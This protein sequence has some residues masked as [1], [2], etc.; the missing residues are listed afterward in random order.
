[1]SNNTLIYRLPNAARADVHSVPIAIAWILGLA[2]A[3]FTVQP[4]SFDVAGIPIQAI[5]I[6]VLF[7]WFVSIRLS[8][9]EHGLTLFSGVQWS[10][11]SV[12]GFS[13]LIRSVSDGDLLRFMQFVTGV[14]LAIVG[15]L[16]FRGA[17][18]RKVI[19]VSLAVTAALSG[20]IAVIQHYEQLSW[21]FERTVYVEGSTRTPSGLETSPVP[22]AYSV[23]GIQVVL[24]SHLIF[25]WRNRIRLMS[26]PL[27]M[28]L[29][30]TLSILAGLVVSQSRSGL[31]G[32]VAAG[33]IL[34]IGGSIV[35]LRILPRPVLIG[36]AVLAVVYASSVKV[37]DEVG[38]T[39]DVRLSTT[40]QAYVPLIWE[41]PVGYAN[42]LESLEFW[43]RVAT[44]DRSASYLAVMNELGGVAPH[45][46]IL[47]T[48]VAYGA[49]AAVALVVLY[50]TV[51]FN[52]VKRLTRLREPHERALALWI[53]TLIATNVA[54]LVHSWFHNANLA[55]GEM[56]NWLW[57]GALSAIT[58]WKTP[59]RVPARATDTS[60]N[61]DERVRQIAR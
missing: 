38:I 26:I 55:T 6:W 51:L 35:G 31:L 20:M 44:V 54:V 15:A 57:I 41:A 27:M 7:V 47:T 13:I 22:F 17:H 36:L 29:V 5:I 40:W 1:M 30:C 21:T 23:V 48:G 32:I 28:S 60:F 56:R 11:V 34:V 8:T 43:D 45:N 59:A 58:R 25:G 4:W 2:L 16:V 46:I 61:D 39:A 3:A 42:A 18:G 10:A 19:I 37:T 53:L 50:G 14:M 33:L 49:P 24:I 12:L 52:G 9:L